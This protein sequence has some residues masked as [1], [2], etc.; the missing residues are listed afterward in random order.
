MQERRDKQGQLMFL[1]STE[2]RGRRGKGMTMRC[3]GCRI[4]RL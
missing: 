4:K 3:L 1:L 2:D